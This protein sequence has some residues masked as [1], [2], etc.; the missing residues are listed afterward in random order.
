MS[1]FGKYQ[2]T[3]F[4]Y[5]KNW[6]FL[7][8]LLSYKSSSYISGYKRFVRCLYF[9]CILPVCGFLLQFFNSVFE[10]QIFLILR[11]SN[12]SVFFS[13]DSAFCI[14]SKKSL[15]MPKSKRLFPIFPPNF[16]MVLAFIKFGSLADAGLIF[17]YGVGLDL[18]FIFLLIW[19]S[20]FS[21]AILSLLNFLSLLIKNQST[22]D[23]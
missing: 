17:V 22:I 19:V 4:T 20:S 12:L 7:C 16:L 14:F 15:P 10:E 11:G 21:K 18:R 5:F 6:S 3:S 9:K 8:L 23:M 1:S 13:F 2:I